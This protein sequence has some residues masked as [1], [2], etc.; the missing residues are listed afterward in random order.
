MTATGPTCQL[1]GQG[2]TRQLSG[3]TRSV[4][5]SHT[6]NTH[7]SYMCIALRQSGLVG[8]VVSRSAVWR[9]RLD[10]GSF[11]SRGSRGN[12]NLS[13]WAIS[14][15]HLLFH[16]LIFCLTTSSLLCVHHSPYYGPAS[17]SNFFEIASD[18]ITSTGDLPRAQSGHLPSQSVSQSHPTNQ[19]S[20]L[21]VFDKTAFGPTYPTSSRSGLLSVLLARLSSKL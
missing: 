10:C 20:F 3:Y 19:S 16:P 1:T 7:H 15:G 18:C 2:P 9:L 4:H 5:Y 12:L 21:F 14:V 13:L 6:H 8:M 11:G 17:T